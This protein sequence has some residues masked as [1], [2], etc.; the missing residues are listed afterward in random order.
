MIKKK[1]FSAAF[2]LIELLVVITII[3]ILAGIALPVFNSVQIKGAQTKVLA[4]AKQVGLALKLYAG[5]NSGS[6]PVYQDLAPTGGGTAAGTNSSN[7]DFFPLFPT[8]TQSESIFANKYCYYN[9]VVPDNVIDTA[10]SLAPTN[11]LKAGENSFGYMEGLSDNLNPACPIVFDGVPTTAEYSTTPNTA[12]YVWGTNK[13]VIIH[14]DNSASLDTLTTTGTS[15]TDEGY[16]PGG[17]STTQIN[18][19]LPSANTALTGCFITVPSRGGGS[20]H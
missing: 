20:T 16:S 18:I 8:Y 15:M 14:L 17:T 13:A 4:Q 1:S 2:T 9:N 7:Q 6:Y 12:G 19:L 5:D 11:T 10:G 3:G